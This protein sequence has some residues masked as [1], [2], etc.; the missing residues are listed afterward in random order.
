MTELEN[1]K[2]NSSFPKGNPKI[3]DVSV[4]GIQLK[5]KTDATPAILKQTKHMVQDRFDDI[6]DKAGSGL[7]QHQKTLLVALNLAEELLAEREKLK[8]LRRKVLESSDAL[9]DRVEAHL[10]K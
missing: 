4:G 2:E 1:T 9:I 8:Q 3:L 5:V 7:D 10:A 6:S